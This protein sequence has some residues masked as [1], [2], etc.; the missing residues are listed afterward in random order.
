M[1]RAIPYIAINFRRDKIWLRRTRP[2]K[3]EFQIV[4]AIDDSKSMG[5][6]G[7][8]R[9]AME[10]PA[11]M[12][13]ALQRLEAGELAVLRFG[14]Q[15]EVLR[16]LAPAQELS[17]ET[18]ASF[19]GAFGFQQDHTSWIELLKCSTGLLQQGR[20][21]YTPRV[22]LDQLLFIISDA[23]I[24]EDRQ[25]VLRQVRLAHEQGRMAVVV[26]LDPRPEASSIVRLKTVTQLDGKLMVHN[27]LDTFPFPYYVVIRRL[28]DLPSV[29][30]DAL[31]Q[32]FAL[33]L[34]EG[35]VTI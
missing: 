24:Q 12:A 2:S 21:R 3:R 20:E 15:V 8:G 34:A 7:A 9:L 32:W 14:A 27:Y 23:R 18:I 22:P 19:C 28:N 29:V 25:Q 16:Q 30:A 33:R 1:R 11:T 35:E 17:G 6:N 4:V 13:L 5:E 10:A 26:I 31:R